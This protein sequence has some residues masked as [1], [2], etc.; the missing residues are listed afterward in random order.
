MASGRRNPERGLI[1]RAL[2]REWYILGGAGRQSGSPLAVRAGG[3][4]PGQYQ[5]V[6]ELALPYL[7]YSRSIDQAEVFAA[8]F[9]PRGRRGR[10]LLRPQFMFDGAGGAGDDGH[11]DE[12][13]RGRHR[14]CTLLFVTPARGPRTSLRAVIRGN[15][16]IAR[17]R[18]RV[19]RVR[20]PC[21]TSSAALAR[22]SKSRVAQLALQ[23]WQCAQSFQVSAA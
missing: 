11:R 1:S 7:I 14:C 21:D 19:A 8:K 4:G 9:A 16:S 20:R 2:A 10:F 3:A 23:I 5:V 15:G 18:G 17:W 6:D 12:Q 22:A 13:T